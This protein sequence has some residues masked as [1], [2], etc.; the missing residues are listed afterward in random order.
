MTTDQDAHYEHPSDGGYFAT[1]LVLLLG[2]LLLRGI[3]PAGFRLPV[4]RLSKGH[5]RPPILHP[6][7]GPT[8]PV[9]QVFRL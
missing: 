1:L 6:P 7:R 3:S 2:T 9:L 8:A 4:P 5:F